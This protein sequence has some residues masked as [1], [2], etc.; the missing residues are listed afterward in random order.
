M[1]WDLLSDECELKL[2]VSFVPSETRYQKGEVVVCLGYAELKELLGKHY[3]GVDRT[4]FDQIS[5]PTML[6][7][8]TK[9]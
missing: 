6:A 1:S 7:I 2:H 5:Q 4:V 9:H 8:N 3:L